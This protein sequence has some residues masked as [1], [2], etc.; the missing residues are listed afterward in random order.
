[1]KEAL[2]IVR[3]SSKEGVTR[4]QFRG[5]IGDPERPFAMP[6]ASP[7]A[8]DE[9]EHNDIETYPYVTKLTSSTVLEGP[10]RP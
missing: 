10:R 7:G 2:P 9:C 3:R 8:A 1:M 5:Q 6:I 4:A